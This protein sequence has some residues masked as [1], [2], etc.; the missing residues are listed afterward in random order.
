MNSHHKAVDQ[1]TKSEVTEEYHDNY[2]QRTLFASKSTAGFGKVG[3]AEI[4]DHEG[5]RDDE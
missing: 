3:C 5:S 2:D 4:V 1:S